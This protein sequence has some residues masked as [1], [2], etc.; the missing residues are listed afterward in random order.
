MDSGERRA[1]DLANENYRYFPNVCGVGF[2]SKFTD[3]ARLENV[4]SIQFFVT[5]KIAPEELTRPLPRFVYAR[6][7][8][9]TLD[10]DRKYP[11]DVID[12]G[13]LNCAARPAT[14]SSASMV[15]ERPR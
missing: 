1:R 15:A 6:R 13:T 12:I 10:R 11:T 9:G 3:G 8:D 4:R 7:A 5:G 14:R 2:G